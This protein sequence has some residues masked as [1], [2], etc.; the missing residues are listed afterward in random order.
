MSFLPRTVLTA[1]G[2]AGIACCALLWS[3]PAVRKQAPKIGQSP[4]YCNPLPIEASSKDGS[5]QG[6]SLG[7]VTIVAEGGLYYMFCTGGG[8]WVSKDLLEWKYQPVEVRGGRL[9]VA[10]HVAKYN[11][12][13]YM[14]GN[15]APLYRASNILGPYEVVGPWKNEK[16][17]P[18]TGVSNGKPWT[19]AFD[20]DIYIDDDNK[21]YLYFPGRSTDGIYVAPLDPKDLTRF[22]AAPKHLFGFK[23]EHVWER[24]GE[25]NEYENVAWIEGPWVF[26][27]RGIYYL[28]YS[29]SGTQWMSYAQGVYTARNPLGPFRYSPRNPLT[30]KTTGVVTGP[31][32]GCV[33][34]APDGT[35][36]V[37]YTIVLPNPPGGRRIGMD[38][39]GFDAQGNPYV[40]S[41]SET[42]QWAPGDVA[43]PVRD[44]DSGSIPLTVNKMRAMNQRG[45]F[46][47][48]KPGR[49]AAYAVDGT[50]G[51]WWEPAEDDRQPTLTVDLGSITEFEDPQYFTVDSSRIVFATGARGGFGARG[52]TGAAPAAPQAAS[53][54][55][56][57]F[58]YKI[59]TSRD[60]KTYETVLDKTNNNVTKY[61]E[62]DELRPTVC[63]FVRLTIT[64]WPRAASPLGILEFTAF[65]KAVSAKRP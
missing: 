12:A 46:S 56:V 30:R 8:A 51:T 23:S 7:D 59:E 42:P 31:G 26:K 53:S 41:V 64:E 1:A 24:W 34:Q 20:V 43:D 50:L 57:A 62:F 37:F 3:Q 10:P 38:P 65:G 14:S 9:P 19:G 63:R 5:P 61:T 27:R 29:A 60:G 18:W 58:R 17:E 32:H 47:S 4:R 22:A 52:G 44:G 40:R 55:P 21:P 13:F 36:W 2:A 35:W 33:V 45:S 16:G 54:G 25:H 6:V 11:G 28:L 48:Q 39:V 15:N 49:D